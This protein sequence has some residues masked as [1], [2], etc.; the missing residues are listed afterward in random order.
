MIEDDPVIQDVLQLIFAEEGWQMVGAT[1]GPAGLDRAREHEPSVVILDMNVPL[2]PGELVAQELH[3]LYSGIPILV[4]TANAQIQDDARRARAF[5]YVKKPFT[6]N[7][8]ITAVNAGFTRRREVST[9][10]LQ[11]FA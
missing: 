9:R 10:A 3:L 2:L 7:A 1:D 6:L 8:L 4:V 5:G 11:E